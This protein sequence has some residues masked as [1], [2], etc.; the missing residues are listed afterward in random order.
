M[1]KMIYWMI[2]VVLLNMVMIPAAAQN[3]KLTYKQVYE[4]QGSRLTEP[5]PSV[6][7]WLD[8]RTYLERRT[9]EKEGKSHT[10]TLAVD[11]VTGASRYH[12]DTTAQNAT[13]PEGFDLAGSSSTTEDG[14]GYLFEK[15]GD[16]YYYNA[17]KDAFKRLT[18][19][20]GE[21]RNPTFSPDGR[22]VA[23]TMRHNLYV[24]EIETGVDY[25]L[26]DDGSTHIKNGYASWVYFEE[27]LG[28]RSQYRAFWWSPDSKKIS[29]LRF[30]DHEVPFFTLYRADYKKDM[31]HGD[32]ETTQYPKPGDPN[33]KVQLG[34][35]DIA[36]SHIVWVDTDPEAD[37]YVCFPMWTPDGAMVFQWM[38]RDQD[39][40]ILYKADLETGAKTVIYEETQQSWI[41]WWTDLYFMKDNSGFILRSDKDGWSHLYHYSWDGSLKK[42]LT[43]GS[44]RVRAISHVDE[45]H[46]I[47]YFTGFKKYSV[48][49]H[50][51]R[52]GLNGK[53][54]KT[55]TTE[56]G[57]HRCIISTDASYFIDSWNS[58]DNPG[59][60]YIKDTQG[61][62]IRR[63]G[64]A[65]SDI[66][67]DYAL[68]K[69][70]L[71]TFPSGDG[72]DLPASWIL[73][74]DFDESKKYPVFFQIYGGPDAANVRNSWQRTSRYWLAQQGIIVISV[75]HR[76]SGHFGKEGVSLMHRCLGKWE[77]KDYVAAVK[78]LR[79][80]TFVDPQ[81]IGMTGSSY[82][83]YMT[84]MCLTAGAPYFTCGIAAMSV[85]DWRLYDSI[86]TE[87]FM[88]RPLDNPEGYKAGSV[89]EHADKLEGALLITHGDMDDNV[90]MQN[91]IQ[92]IS[93]L[94]DEGKSFEFMVY[95]GGRHGWRGPK[96]THSTRAG[97]RFWFEHLLN[98]RTF[99]PDVD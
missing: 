94:Q 79:T 20:K 61:K 78:Y 29:F 98:G 21:E 51:F 74:P 57:T 30:D 5:L 43:K 27:I 6:R 18:A 83:G 35:V 3:K 64:S 13:L 24:T 89:M 73:P 46:G 31:I 12:P 82:G 14:N 47:V 75:D 59:M 87:R 91:S 53:G 19:T 4:R 65:E 34:V 42:R 7:E 55:L 22:Y 86:Y 49:N 56:R 48:D 26:T 41:D 16:L 67:K 93:K 63:L 37:H 97:I 54:L 62:E 66:L 11:A 38:N 76:G 84:A 33:P 52:V 9:V 85:T 71:F 72:Y 80:K 45:A 95:P 96:R 32:L 15:D 88:D 44:W 92:L 70:E 1:R 60:M 50:L 99:D 36:D 25:Q 69:A 81:R 39:H 77:V 17:D 23:Y 28:R 40:C 8:G 68:G 58:I 10:A 90:H 2:P